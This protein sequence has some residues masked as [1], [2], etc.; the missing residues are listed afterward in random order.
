M[1][2]ANNLQRLQQSFEVKS[3][4][5]SFDFGV[6]VNTQHMATTIDGLDFIPDKSSFRKF[7]TMQ[8]VD[9]NGV[10]T[11]NQLT[12]IVSAGG[13]CQVTSAKSL[14]QAID[15]ANVLEN[16]LNE[17]G[18]QGEINNLSEFQAYA[19]VEVGALSLEHVIHSDPRFVLDNCQAVATIDSVRI[20]I[21]SNGHVKLRGPSIE[22]MRNSLNIITGV[23]EVN[24]PA[25]LQQ[26]IQ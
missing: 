26:N 1:A 20:K 22:E 6:N 23:L 3:T 19:N 14:Q 7:I 10:I 16:F 13:R 9:S 18:Y 2:S 12:C 21:K 24:V 11:E 17:N 8:F 5:M 4:G 15:G 25:P